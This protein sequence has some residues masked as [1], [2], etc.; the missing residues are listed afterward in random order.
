LGDPTPIALPVA[1][2]ISPHD[3]PYD[4]TPDPTPGWKNAIRVGV[5]PLG[6]FQGSG[7]MQYCMLGSPPFPPHLRRGDPV[8][9]PP[10]IVRGMRAVFKEFPRRFP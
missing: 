9:T 10:R 2:A 1:P 3:P 6:G 5:P 8:T 7:L 4:P